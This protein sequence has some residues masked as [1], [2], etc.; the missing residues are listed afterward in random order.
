MLNNRLLNAQF[1]HIDFNKHGIAHIYRAAQEGI[2]FAFRYGL[3]I[4]RQNGMQPSVIRAGKAN[5]FLSDVFTS[6]FVNTLQVP[7]ELY[8]C[9]GSHGA[10]IGSGIGA[11]IYKN[12]AEA[13][14][15][16]TPVETIRPENGN[17]YEALYGRWL[18]QLEKN[19][20]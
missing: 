3:D 1:L 18:E 13:F 6:A 14:S 11:G 15:N 7:V 2:V 5:M 20:N 8:N 16:F 10:A 12:P 17:D 19:L 4:M 9:D